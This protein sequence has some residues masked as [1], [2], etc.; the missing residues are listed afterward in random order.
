MLNRVS[1]LRT[2]GVLGLAPGLFDA[3][4]ASLAGLTG[5]LY[6]A[7]FFELG[8][9]GL[10]SV[11]FVAFQL[12][13]LL[14]ARL[15]TVPAQVVA[16][17]LPIPERT[18]ILSKSLPVGLVVGLLAAPLV[19]V[20]PLLAP[21]GARADYVAFA[22]TTA[23]MVLISP[24][25]DHCRFMLHMS[26]QSQK[27][28]AVSASQFV[29]ALVALLSMHVLD[30]PARWLPFLSLGIANTVSTSFAV[31][32][33]RPSATVAIWPGVSSLLASGRL[34]LPAAVLPLAGLF[35]TAVLVAR[36]ASTDALGSAEAARVV[37]SPVLVAGVGLG[38]V[39]WPR[40]MSGARTHDSEEL[41]RAAR[42]FA[43]AVLLLSGLYVA[44]VGWPHRLNVMEAL[45]PLAYT[46]TGLVA[47]R[48]LASVSSVL[49]NIPG[50]ALLG[51]ENNRRL[52]IAAGCAVT[53][54]LIIAA[55]TASALGAHAVP[56]AELAGSIV[57][58]LVMLPAVPGFAP[59]WQRRSRAA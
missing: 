49:A 51:L 39:L 32:L 4:F 7:R 56:A 35:G 27:A 33:A 3:G 42:T 2:A 59:L 17:D 38:Q 41:I 50:S 19:L 10:F 24:L 20:V 40:I 47:F 22:A 57:S 5:S 26:G 11:F 52:L 13:Q 29:V 31:M 46:V 12:L 58:A 48:T 9:L 54:Q 53:V 14:P 37:A 36:L 21:D 43:L 34:L 1:R 6:A 28:A 44:V 18:A 16:L 15:I 23:L 45:I 25:Q 55:V 8:Q 30:I